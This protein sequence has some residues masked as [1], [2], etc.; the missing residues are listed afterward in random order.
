VYPQGESRTVISFDTLV[1]LLDLDKL[2]YLN[3]KIADRLLDI[4]SR[5]DLT[6]PNGQIA[7]NLI[8]S[9]MAGESE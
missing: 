2:T 9:A 4:S 1:E 7:M 5:S 8:E 6:V 3:G